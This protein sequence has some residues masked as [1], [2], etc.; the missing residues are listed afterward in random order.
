MKS[1]QGL[2]IFQNFKFAMQ[3]KESATRK[4]LKTSKSW[5]TK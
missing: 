4:G 3:N 2:N 5:S 1:L